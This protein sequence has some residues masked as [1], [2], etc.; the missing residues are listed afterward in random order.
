MSD[1]VDLT[2]DFISNKRDALNGIIST[3]DE[4]KDL[5]I[6]NECKALQDF[7]DKTLFTLKTYS[8]QMLD[9][10][11]V[12]HSNV[13]LFNDISSIAKHLKYCVLSSF[14]FKNKGSERYHID[15]NCFEANKENDYIFAM[16]VIFDSNDPIIDSK[17]NEFNF[18]ITIVPSDVR[19]YIW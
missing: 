15:C 6:V 1:C 9:N 17:I 10:E 2:K 5:D 12:K 3:F 18:S 7:L 11:V 16:T 19:S 14:G 13:S 4:V 8:R